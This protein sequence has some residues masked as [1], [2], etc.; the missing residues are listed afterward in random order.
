MTVEQI[1]REL[2]TADR[3]CCGGKKGLRAEEIGRY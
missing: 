1:M 3:S 2:R